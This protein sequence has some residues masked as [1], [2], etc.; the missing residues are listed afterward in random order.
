M[1]TKALHDRSPVCFSGVWPV[2]S[3][4]T[5]R[6]CPRQCLHIH[7][8]FGLNCCYLPLHPSPGSFLWSLLEYY[9]L[10]NLLLDFSLGPGSNTANKLVT[11]YM[12]ITYHKSFFTL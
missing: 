1:L 12:L 5:T 8:S 11:L 4:D 3:S 10:P 6:L 2:S 7:C 9:F